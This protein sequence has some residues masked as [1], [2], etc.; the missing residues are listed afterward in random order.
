LSGGI[1]SIAIAAW[2]RPDHAVTIDYGQRPAPAEI[3]AARAASRAL[4]L[5][6]HILHIDCSELGTGEMVG[7]AQLPVAPTPEW[8]PFRNQML[9]TFAAAHLLRFGVSELMIGTLSTDRLSTDGSP[10]FLRKADELLSM[11][12][13]GMRLIAPASNL[14]VEELLNES[15]VPPDLVALSHSCHVAD[16]P[17]GYC[18]GCAKRRLLLLDEP[19]RCCLR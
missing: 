4:G 6:H 18:R 12:E 5:R 15:G 10:D 2:R 11:Q 8:W 1:D 17:C 16:I 3:A 19:H 14:T 7:A 13:G 9:I